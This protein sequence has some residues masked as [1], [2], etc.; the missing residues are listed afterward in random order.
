MTSKRFSPDFQDFIDKCLDKKVEHRWS[1]DMLF[2]HPFLAGAEN[3]RE[4][5]CA[6]FASWQVSEN[7]R[8]GTGLP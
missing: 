4:Q 5:W 8:N 6:D 1:T 2:H 7:E 3:M